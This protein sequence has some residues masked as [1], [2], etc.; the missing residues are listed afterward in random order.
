MHCCG[1]NGDEFSVWVPHAIYASK[2]ESELI[3]AA[4]FILLVL[5]ETPS[6]SRAH[7]VGRCLGLCVHLAGHGKVTELSPHPALGER[8]VIAEQG[9]GRIDRAKGW[10]VAD[11]L[12]HQ[13]FPASSANCPH[14][15][16]LGHEL[17]AIAS[18]DRPINLSGRVLRYQEPAKQSSFPMAQRW[19]EG[20]HEV[21]KLPV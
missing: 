7:R 21:G 9:P 18:H 4:L 5:D 1:E 16:R 17:V 14:L 13:N 8:E 11:P 2:A 20:R 6:V 15:E 10:I 12:L 3:V 19:G